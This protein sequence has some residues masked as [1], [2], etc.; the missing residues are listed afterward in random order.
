MI[1]KKLYRW[2]QLMANNFILTIG[3]VSK[4]CHNVYI[5]FIRK[6]TMFQ[7]HSVYRKKVIRKKP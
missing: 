5:R 7:V 6:L 3:E 4:L 1:S 2:F